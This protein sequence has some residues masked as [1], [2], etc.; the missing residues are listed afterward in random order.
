M[1][2]NCAFLFTLVI[3]IVLLSSCLS[4]HDPSEYIDEEAIIHDSEKTDEF[5][6]KSEETPESTNV[7]TEDDSRYE[8]KVF[9]IE[10]TEGGFGYNIIEDGKL[11]I[12]QTSIPSV[13]G[14]RG[15]SSQEKAM[16]VAEFV[17]FKMKNKIFPP[18]VDRAELDSLQVLD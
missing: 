1:K 16:K 8:A 5:I 9:Q 10:G 17:I 14:I 18:T 11:R 15:F 3:S 4:R 2:K 12:H 7:T 13:A 6:K